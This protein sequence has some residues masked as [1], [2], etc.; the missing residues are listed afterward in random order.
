MAKPNQ[1]NQGAAAPQKSETMTP[2]GNKSGGSRP[3]T[4]SMDNS[5]KNNVVALP[6]MCLTEGCKN[7]SEKANFCM[8]H[9]DW[10]KE[11]LVTKEGRKPTDFEKK[12]FNYMRR[13]NKKVA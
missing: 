8:E 3:G 13:K 6:G 10:F 11:G 5:K 7:K 1:P 12:H 2:A 4:V 9:F